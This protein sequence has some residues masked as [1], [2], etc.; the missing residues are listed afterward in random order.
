MLDITRNTRKTL[1]REKEKKKYKKQ[2]IR[3][4]S[5]KQQ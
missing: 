5:S 1:E 4:K 2:K 3:E